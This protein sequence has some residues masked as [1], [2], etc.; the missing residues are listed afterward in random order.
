ME[1]IAA[2]RPTDWDTCELHVFADIHLGDLLVDGK[3]LQERIA[4]CEETENCVVVLNGDI[5]NA[6]VKSSVSDVYAESVR[7]MEQLKTAVRYFGKLAEQGKILALTDGNHERRVYRNDGIDMSA[8]IAAQLGVPYS[9]GAAMIF[10]RFGDERQHHRRMLYTIFCSHGTGGGSKI[11]SKASRLLNMSEI[12]DA[13]IF[14]HSHV[15][16]PLIVKRAFFRTNAGNSSVQR[17]DRLYINTAAYLDY[18]SYAEQSELPAGSK[19]TP[20]VYLD[21][22][23]RNMI[24]QM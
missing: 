6:A 8:I 3:L 15:H 22:H 13:D 17:V 12:C 14:V 24:A 21:G 18:G 4:H 19:A 1:T 5:C 2:E 11:G 10:L 20:V 16:E 23:R 9:P 7:P